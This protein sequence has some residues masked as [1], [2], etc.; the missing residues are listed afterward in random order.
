MN[1]SQRNQAKEWI[2]LVSV[3]YVFF[4]PG[5]S[6]FAQTQD[7]PEDPYERGLVLLK[8]FKYEEAKISLTRAYLKIQTI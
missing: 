8:Q 6:V 3:L 7:L 1:K 5:I 4:V 2:A